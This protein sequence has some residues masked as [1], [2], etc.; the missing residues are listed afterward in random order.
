MKLLATLII[1]VVVGAFIWFAIQMNAE[2]NECEAA[3][4]QYIDAGGH[5]QTQ[6]MWVNG[7]PIITQ[8][9]IPN[10]VCEGANQ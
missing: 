8:N 1:A 7:A 5:Y 3:G 10:Y 6:T 2:R 9:Y 4:G